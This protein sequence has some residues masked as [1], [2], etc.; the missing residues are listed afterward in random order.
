MSYRRFNLRSATVQNLAGFDFY[1]KDSFTP[2]LLP[3]GREIIEMM[4]HHLMPRGKGYTQKN[5]QGAAEMISGLLSE[6]WIWCNIYPKS[7]VSIA[8]SVLNLYDN[9]KNLRYTSKARQTD[10]WMETK[11]KPFLDMLEKGFDIAATDHDYIKKLEKVYRVK[12][13]ESETDFYEDQ[14]NGERKMF[15]D[16]LFH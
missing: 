3:T 2:G 6:H 9:F 7:M 1:A 16:D 5:K 4:V 13:T 15:C 8:K 11:A 10:T 12:M 14:V